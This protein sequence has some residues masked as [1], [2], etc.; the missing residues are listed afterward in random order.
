MK[1]GKVRSLAVCV[2]RDRD[3]IF[4]SEIS[5]RQNQQT[6]YRPLGGA[7]DFGE[8]S[9]EAAR[10]ELEEE[11]GAEITDMKYLGIIENVYTYKG[12]PGHEI[13]IVY[14][15][16]FADDSLYERAWLPRLDKRSVRAVWKPL[17]DFRSGQSLLYPEGLLQLLSD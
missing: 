3:R 4:I 6:F 14:Q 17:V 12:K 5:D 9:E 16:A 1:A 11:I 10:R 2:I 7:I 15:G 13:M 8:L